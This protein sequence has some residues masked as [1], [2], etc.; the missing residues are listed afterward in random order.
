MARFKLVKISRRKVEVQKVR[1]KIHFGIL[2][3][4]FACAFLVWLY[5]KGSRLPE[6]GLLEDTQ[7]NETVAAETETTPETETVLGETDV[8]AEMYASSLKPENG[9]YACEA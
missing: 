8:T 4:A 9:G 5:V 7:P 3:G 1:L 2:L 6:P